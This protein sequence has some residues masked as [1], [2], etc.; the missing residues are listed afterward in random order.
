MFPSCF[1]QCGLMFKA[2]PPAQNGIYPQKTNMSPS[3]NRGYI[4]SSNGWNFP[5]P[6]MVVNSG[7]FFGRK[8]L[9]NASK[10][11]WLQVTHLHLNRSMFVKNPTYFFAKHVGNVLQLVQM[12]SSKTG[13]TC[14]KGLSASHHIQLAILSSGPTRFHRTKNSPVDPGFVR[15]CTKTLHSRPEKKKLAMIS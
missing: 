15:F 3:F 6:A 13:P 11:K 1:S 8:L 7:G 12:D 14:L 4:T 9:E 10:N 5:L 2:I